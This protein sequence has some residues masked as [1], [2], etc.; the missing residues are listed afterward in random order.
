MS[1]S[2]PRPVTPH[3][4][5]LPQY[6]RQTGSIIS[7]RAAK[8]IRRFFTI[9]QP[10]AEPLWQILKQSDRSNY[11]LPTSPALALM[12]ST[13]FHQTSCALKLTF[14]SANNL[15]C[16]YLE[17]LLGAW[18]RI[19]RKGFPIRLDL[20][21]Q[22]D[23]YSTASCS[24]CA[25]GPDLL[26]F[27]FFTLLFMFPIFYSSNSIK[28]QSHFSKKKRKKKPL[29]SL[30]LLSSFLHPVLFLTRIVPLLLI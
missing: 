2:S 24:N 29:F 8:T 18:L 11:H 28:T 5:I 17:Y 6:I 3:Q 30:P 20:W 10:R 9:I 4:H 14:T 23:H 13:T 22:R 1:V 21:E 27:T 25:N 7:S 26:S 12:K 15:E 16:S 19:D